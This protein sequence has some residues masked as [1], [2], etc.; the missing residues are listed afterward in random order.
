MLATAVFVL[1]SWSQSHLDA[2]RDV[3]PFKL[4]IAE[5]DVL[6]MRDENAPVW[7]KVSL[8][9]LDT[10]LGGGCYNDANPSPPTSI[11]V[12]FAP[13][14]SPEVKKKF[15]DLLS[16]HGWTEKR[17]QVQPWNDKPEW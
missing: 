14:V 16:R 1:L 12:Q 7:Y 9:T 6:S 2:R 17:I 11:K 3:C 15:L 5:N 8:K 10:R 4:R 13:M